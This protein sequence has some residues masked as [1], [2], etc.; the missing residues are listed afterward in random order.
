MSNTKSYLSLSDYLV[1]RF[2]EKVYKLSLPGGTTCPNRDGTLGDRGCIFCGEQGSGE[3]SA[4]KRLSVTQQIEAGKLQ[5]AGKFKGSKYIA[6]FQSFTSTYGDLAEMRARFFEAARHPD[7]VAVSVATRP[8]CL[9]GEVLKILSELAPIKPLFVELGLQT[10]HESTAKYIRRGYDLPVF[11]EAVQNLKAIG[12]EVVVHVILGLPF[13]SRA[14]MLETVKYVADSGADGIKLQLLHVLKGTDLEKEYLA[15]KFETLT[16]EE[17]VEIVCEAL[18]LLP[19][20]MVVHRLTG[21]GDKRL[22]VA[23]L[24]SADKKRV[25]QRQQEMLAH[26]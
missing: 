25:M 19:S 13:E 1:R 12:A 20:G 5:V 8:D 7:I 24:W 4:N 6:Y 15:G 3:F 17:Y 18:A 21:D 16:L 22:L 23:P 2:G 9:G 26:L 11:V 14:D 10:I